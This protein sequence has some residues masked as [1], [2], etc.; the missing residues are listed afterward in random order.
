MVEVQTS[1]MDEIPAPFSLV[2]QW[3]RNGKHCREA[4]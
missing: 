4:R 3:V 1:E 2:Q